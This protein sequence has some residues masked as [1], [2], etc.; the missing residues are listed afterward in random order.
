MAISPYGKVP[1]VVIEGQAI[2]ESAI[3]NE[4]LDEVFPAVPLMPQDPWRRAQVRIWTDYTA[5]RLVPPM[6]RVLK[7]SDP[8]K[9]ES[10]W[11]ELHAELSYLNNHLEKS[12]GPWLL[13]DEFSMADINMLP[14]VHQLPRL[15]QDVMGQYAGINQFYVSFQQ[16]PSYQQTLQDS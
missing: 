5:S 1:V 13:G 3:I 14:F 11:P 10:S 2:F 7:S 8:K 6:Y 15:D 9:V 12:D 16:R 4:Y